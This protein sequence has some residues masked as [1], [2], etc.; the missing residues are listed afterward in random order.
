MIIFYK[1]N[2][3]PW[4]SYQIRKIAGA[5]APGM[6][7]TFSPS[8]QVSDPDMHHGTCVTH[9]PWC[10]PGSL[11]SGFLWNRRRGKKRSRHSRRM[12]NLQFYVSG[13][14]PIVGMFLQPDL[15]YH[16]DVAIIW[17]ALCTTNQTLTTQASTV[18]FLRG[19][20]CKLQQN[21]IRWWLYSYLFM[22]ICIHESLSHIYIYIY[23]HKHMHMYIHIHIHYLGGIMLFH[24]SFK[25]IIL[26]A[27]SIMLLSRNRVTTIFTVI[28]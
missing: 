9:V 15:I 20:C 4:A 17:I 24:V 26:S 1:I 16:S 5:H 22:H 2:L 12:R 6:P 10:M 25:Y 8:Q 21:Y 27:S 11:T 19:V 13:K 7:G 28:S 14:R 3:T 23:I 18:V